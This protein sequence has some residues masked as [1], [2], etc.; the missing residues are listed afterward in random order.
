MLAVGVL[1]TG[2]AYFLY[3]RLIE[4]LGPAKAMTVTFLVPVF[5]LLYGN[6]LLHEALTL[7]MLLCGAVVV[8]GTALST[9]LLRLPSSVR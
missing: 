3:F 8:L 9:G 4:R 6:I 1:C 7:H 5:A 2:L